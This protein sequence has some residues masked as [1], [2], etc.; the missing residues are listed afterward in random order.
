MY[1]GLWILSPWLSQIFFWILPILNWSWLSLCC[2]TTLCRLMHLQLVGTCAH[3]KKGD[4]T[5]VWVLQTG[6]FDFLVDVIFSNC[7]HDFN[8]L[9]LQVIHFNTGLVFFLGEHSSS[10]SVLII[11]RPPIFFSGKVPS[12]L[13]VNLF[14]V[15]GLEHTWKIFHHLFFTILFIC[16]IQSFVLLSNPFD[17]G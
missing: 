5:S 15:Y 2:G 7:K 14:L 11:E 17:E 13:S 4:K 8:N 6:F 16:T 1:L 12:K 3:Q 9:Q 10:G